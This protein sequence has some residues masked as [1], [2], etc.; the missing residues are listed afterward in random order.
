MEGSA[1]KLRQRSSGRRGNA[2]RFGTM[3]VVSVINYKGGVGKTTLTANLA[4]YLACLGKRVLLVDMDPQCSLTLSFMSEERWKELSEGGETLKGWFDKVRRNQ[5]GCPLQ[6]SPLVAHEKLVVN[7]HLKRYGFVGSVSLIPS[8][9]DLMDVDLD[10]A[11]MLYSRKG[12]E[13]EM[14]ERFVHLHGILREYIHSSDME[15]FDAVLVDCPPNFNIVTKTAIVASD[16]I[17]TPVVPDEMSTRGVR[18]LVDKC[19][20]LANGRDGQKG[21]NSHSQILGKEVLSIPNIQAIVPM[22][23]KVTSTGS[24][25]VS[26]AHEQ[27]VA[28]LKADLPDIV[29]AGGAAIVRGFRHR[30]SFFANPEGIPVFIQPTRDCG[31]VWGSVADAVQEVAAQLGWNAPGNVRLS[32]KW[33]DLSQYDPKWR[34]PQGWKREFAWKLS[35]LLKDAEEES[36]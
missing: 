20:E 21:F 10:L 26:A 19:E 32:E 31:D 3:K 27:F 34:R 25:G 35:K 18:H 33:A 23:W 14:A 30:S 16:S 28:R 7:G 9:I 5:V 13:Q 11:Q 1:V 8:D 6:L 12:E 36:K 17:V 22:I 2:P 4:A 24:G 15:E 29:R